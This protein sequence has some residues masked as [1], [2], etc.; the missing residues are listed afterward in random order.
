MGMEMK[1]PSLC[2]DMLAPPERD[3]EARTR[4]KSRS[5]NKISREIFLTENEISREFSDWERDLASE[6]ESRIL[7]Q[8]HTRSLLEISKCTYP[9]PVSVNSFLQNCF[10][11]PLSRDWKHRHFD[12]EWHYICYL[13]KDY[14]WLLR[15]TNHLPECKY[16]TCKLQ[17][18]CAKSPMK[19]SD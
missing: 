11:N 14:E 5:E 9:S 8:F 17:T 13:I 2:C 18:K 19:Q 12:C 1:T 4:T 3:L 10:Y 6:V 7:L 15:P 16:C